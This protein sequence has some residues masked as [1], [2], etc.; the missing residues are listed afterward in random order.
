MR[1]SCATMTTTTTTARRRDPSQN[2][3]KNLTTSELAVHLGFRETFCSRPRLFRCSTRRRVLL[4]PL[5]RSGCSCTRERRLENTFFFLIGSGL[6]KFPRTRNK[7][8]YIHTSNWRRFVKNVFPANI[9]TYGTRAVQT[10]KKRCLRRG[11][12]LWI[13]SWHQF[14]SVGTCIS[15]TLKIFVLF[16]ILVM[17]KVS[18]VKH[19]NMLIFFSS[20]FFSFFFFSFVSTCFYY[21]HHLFL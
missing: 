8:K 18:V 6:L 10:F 13:I 20:T 3:I 11:F 5:F 1:T 16:E 19:L 17:R 2:G 12:Y 7:Q 4:R 14:M 9:K 21:D 15:R